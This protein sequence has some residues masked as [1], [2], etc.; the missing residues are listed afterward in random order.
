MVVEGG[1]GWG[2]WSA[3]R[4]RSPRSQR[5]SRTA[6]L[7]RLARI[8]GKALR[9]PFIVNVVRTIFIMSNVRLCVEDQWLAQN[10]RFLTVRFW[11]EREAGDGPASPRTRGIPFA[12]FRLIIIS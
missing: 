9:K 10:A 5:A 4:D 2:G 6:R 8:T 3:R 12:L 11:I 1:G 7:L